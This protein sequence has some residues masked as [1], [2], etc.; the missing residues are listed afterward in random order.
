MWICNPC[1]RR[2]RLAQGFGFS[3]LTK[4][5][6]SDMMGAVWSL[7]ISGRTE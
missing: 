7:L 3:Y 5:Y 4:P 6:Q 2:V 1:A